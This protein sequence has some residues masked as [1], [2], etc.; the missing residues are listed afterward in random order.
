ML[1][2]HLMEYAP[3]NERKNPLLALSRLRENPRIPTCK[4]IRNKLKYIILSPNIALT[5]SN[6]PRNTQKTITPRKLKS[7][8]RKNNGLSIRH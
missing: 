4:K 5:Y 2:T 6:S 1:S 8:P 7:R 3:Q